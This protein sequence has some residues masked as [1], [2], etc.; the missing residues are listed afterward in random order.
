MLAKRQQLYWVVPA[1]MAL[2]YVFYLVFQVG[3]GEIV[4][5]LIHI[6]GAIEGGDAVLNLAEASENLGQLS[7]IRMSPFRFHAKYT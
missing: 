1:A 3:D 6:Y 2:F 4:Q 7:T 5:D